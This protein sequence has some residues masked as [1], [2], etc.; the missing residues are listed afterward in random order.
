MA[1]T[2][3]RPVDPELGRLAQARLQGL[4]LRVDQ[5]RHG[6]A[7]G[8]RQRQVLGHL[9]F[10]GAATLR[11]RLERERAAEDARARKAAEAAR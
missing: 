1:A 3:D 7:P 11:R 8:Q 6:Q 4:G 10:D 2:T 5:A 9:E